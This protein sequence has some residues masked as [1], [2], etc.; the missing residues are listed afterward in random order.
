M[1]VE[2]GPR[3]NIAA[4]VRGTPPDSL[5]AKLQTTLETIHLQWCDPLTAFN[6]DAAAFAPQRLV[7]WLI[8]GSVFDLEVATLVALPFVCLVWLTPDTPSIPLGRI[9]PCQCTLVCS[10][11]LLV[12]KM[13]TRSPST[14]S[15]VGPGDWPL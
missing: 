15:M 11:S 9:W 13:R 5:P 4:V 2:T 12:T 6:G 8:V 7:G 3:A 10:G 1:L 14:T